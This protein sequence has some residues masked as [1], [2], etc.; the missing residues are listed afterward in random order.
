MLPAFGGPEYKPYTLN[1][2]PASEAKKPRAAI[3]GAL[4]QQDEV[5]YCG[6]DWTMPPLSNSRITRVISCSL[7][8]LKGVIWGII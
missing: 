3:A 4:K 1:P 8:P 5:S 2:E 6:V 7:K